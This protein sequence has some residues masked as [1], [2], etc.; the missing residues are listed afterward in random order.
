MSS[1]AEWMTGGGRAQDAHRTAGLPG[2]RTTLALLHG[3]RPLQENFIQ[4]VAFDEAHASAALDAYSRF[5][6]GRHPAAL[7][8]GDCCAY[9]VA[10][11]AGGRCCAPETTSP[12]PI[13][14]WSASIPMSCPLPRNNR[15]YAKV[16]PRPSGQLADPSAHPGGLL[17]THA[18]ETGNETARR[19]LTAASGRSESG[20]RL[21]HASCAV[22]CRVSALAMCPVN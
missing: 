2:R 7:N 14:S 22:A 8:F 16:R 3:A 11:V 5:G 19:A 18:N 17:G 21:T 12:A 13:C 6:K 15:P 9:A 1:R 20:S 10:S 4:T